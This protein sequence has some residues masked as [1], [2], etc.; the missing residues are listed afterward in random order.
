MANLLK[1]RSASHTSSYEGFDLSHYVNF[2]SSV[3]H[4]LPIGW[5]FVLPGDKMTI[6]TS[7]KSILLPM[8]SASP[9]NLTEH[10]DYYFVPLQTL[11]SLFPSLLSDTNEDN[12]NSLFDKEYYGDFFP[13]TDMEALKAMHYAR[14]TQLDDFG[15][16]TRFRG[17]YRVG[18]FFKIGARV[19]TTSA[20]TVDKQNLLLWQAYNAVYQFFFRD[21]ARQ[22]FDPSKFNVDKYYQNGDIPTEAALNITQIYYRQWKKDPYTITK[23]SPL[24]SLSS[25]NHFAPINDADNPSNMFQ[26]FVKQ[27]LQSFGSET[28]S[29]A[30]LDG[31]KP[32]SNP[33]NFVGEA[34]GSDVVGSPS[35]ASTDVNFPNYTREYDTSQ[36]LNAHRIAQAIE[37]LSAIWQQSGKNYKDFMTNL[38]G[39]KGVKDDQTRPLY[40]GSDSNIIT[41]NPEVA[42]MTTGSGSG[43]NF[44]AYT[45]AGQITGR[46]YGENHAEGVKFEARQHGIILALY[47]CVPDAVYAGDATDMVNYY[48][49][50]GS[51]PNPVTDELGEQPFFAF[52]LDGYNLIDEDKRY[53]NIRGWLPR[54][55]ELK[56]KENR[57]YGAFKRSLAYWIPTRDIQAY[58]TGNIWTSFYIPPTYLDPIMLQGYVT[59]PT[60]IYE[61]ITAKGD[62]FTFDPIMHFFKF[63]WYKSSKMSSYGVPST[64][65]G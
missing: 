1:P 8:N 12:V 17:F 28:A 37:K 35:T 29:Q 42:N 52:E 43:D 36:S 33:I 24:G 60:I 26:S 3:G 13:V 7:M 50:R 14:W 23:P 19:Y 5:D 20:S 62:M 2:T 18:E 11:Y 48:H 39:V 49:K 45:E 22:E 30:H 46:G 64:Y 63:D 53:S 4:V 56:M 44:E 15:F 55:H 65:F 57:A 58:W 51:F 10:V 40:I 27:W 31:F 21:D 59:D 38:F 61:G 6:K 9:V 16:D 41:I 47:S 54:F 25:K 32:Y 34:E